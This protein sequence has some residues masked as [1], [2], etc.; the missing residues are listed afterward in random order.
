MPV[1]L[2]TPVMRAVQPLSEKKDG[3]EFFEETVE[4][5]AAERNKGRLRLPAY[6]YLE[7]FPESPF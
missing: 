7:Y 4:L 2:P 1:G 6:V 3:R 5:M